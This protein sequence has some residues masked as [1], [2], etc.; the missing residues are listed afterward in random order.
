[1][2]MLQAPQVERAYDG[3]PIIEPLNLRILPGPT[4]ALVGPNGCGK[5]T[6][7][8]GLSRLLKPGGGMV[9][10]GGKSIQTLSAK[11]AAKQIGILPQSPVAPEGLTIHELV[12]QGRYPH[13]GWFQQW[14][15]EMV[16]RVFRLECQIT[17]APIAGTPLCPLIGR[18][19]RRVALSPETP[20]KRV[21]LGRNGAAR[22]ES[23]L[24]QE[25]D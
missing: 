10:L 23:V 13:Q 24:S 15:A 2:K 25:A 17:T 7:P 11:G 14:S 5:S 3:E 4:M 1:M 9:L 6:L 21:A 8:R 16:K 18:G 12:A 20:E 22:P 19:H